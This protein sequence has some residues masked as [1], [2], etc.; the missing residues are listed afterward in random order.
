MIAVAPLA[1]VA[2]LVSKLMLEE[3]FAG[4]VLEI[5]VVDPALADGFIDSLQMCLSNKSPIAKR[6]STTGRPL[7]P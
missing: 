6:V 4:K 5:L 2:Q 7:S 1:P 3:L